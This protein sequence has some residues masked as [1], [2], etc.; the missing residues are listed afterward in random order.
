MSVYAELE[1]RLRQIE[2]RAAELTKDT[3]VAGYS[4]RQLL[5][6]QQL[7]F[8][9]GQNPKALAAAVNQAPTS[10]TPLIDSLEIHSLTTRLPDASDRRSVKIV[11]TRSAKDPAFRMA[12]LDTLAIIEDEF[13]GWL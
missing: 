4:M 3:A 8:H 7:Y 2:K 11:L 5:L 6:L 12:V 10:V 13:K 1:K 9:D